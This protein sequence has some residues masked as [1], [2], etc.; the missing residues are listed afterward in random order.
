LSSFVLPN[1]F[2]AVP[3]ASGPIFMFCAVEL[4]LGGTEGAG[5]QFSCFAPSYSLSVVPWASGPVFIFCAAGLFFGGTD[6]VGSHFHVLSC[7][8]RLGRYRGRWVE[9]SCFALPESF[10]MVPKASSP[11]F[12]FSALVL[13]FDGNIRAGSRCHVLCS[14]THFGRYQLRRVPFSCSALLDSFWMVCDPFLRTPHRCEAMGCGRRTQR[15][16]LSVHLFSAG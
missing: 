12:M 1:S 7:R 6:G 3:M 14:R 13:L 10:S 15:S 16:L 9:F 2:W 4:I 8:T 11:V 5:V